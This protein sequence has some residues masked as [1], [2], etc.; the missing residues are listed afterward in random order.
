MEGYEFDSSWVFGSLFDRS[1]EE[2]GSKSGAFFFC[3]G[4][5]W[6]LSVSSKLG[7]FETSWKLNTLDFSISH[8]K[9]V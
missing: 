7:C 1:P 5:I 9:A 4:L 8:G 3:R 2:L 6:Y